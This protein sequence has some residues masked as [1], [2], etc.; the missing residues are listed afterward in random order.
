MIRK[1][2]GVSWK[3]YLIDSLF[4][5]FLC[6]N[7][8]VYGFERGPIIKAGLEPSA[9]NYYTAIPQSACTH[10]INTLRGTPF[11]TAPGPNDA[12][13]LGTSATPTDQ[14]G[15]PILSGS[16]HA[17]RC[18]TKVYYKTHKITVDM[19]ESGS[20]SFSYDSHGRLLNRVQIAR[21]NN[22]SYTQTLSYHYDSFGRLD[23]TT[24]PSGTQITT[25]YGA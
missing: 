7:S 24:Y 8:L 13:L 19:D 1:L 3:K 5:F 14:N 4:F 6:G 16:A 11:F 25:S 22:A 21:I 15:Y 17:Y 18:D 9:P 20:T 2:V 10:S 23:Q 12:D